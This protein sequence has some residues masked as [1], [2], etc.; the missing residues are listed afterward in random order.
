[1][2]DAWARGRPLRVE[3][4]VVAGADR[5]QPVLRL[6]PRDAERLAGF[7]H[8][9]LYEFA[10]QRL[11]AGRAG[12]L[13]VLQWLL[14]TGLAPLHVRRSWRL[15]AIA[16]TSEWNLALR[17]A[18]IAG[19]M[20]LFLLSLLLALAISLLQIPT[21]LPTLQ[22]VAAEVVASWSWLTGLGLAV[23]LIAA[24]LAVSMAWGLVADAVEEW[25]LRRAQL[26]QGWAGGYAGER[27]LWLQAALI[28]LALTSA[29]A[30]LAGFASR[31]AW[32]AVASALATLAANPSLLRATMALLA[33]GWSWRWLRSHLG[34]IALYVKGAA[35]SPF[36]RTRARLQAA[37]VAQ[38]RGLLLADAGYEVVVLVGHSLGSVL[39]LDALDI[40]AMEGATGGTSGSSPDL[41][42]L[43]GL[44]TFGS[45]LDKV[46]YLFRERIADDEA[47]RSQ[48]VAFWR[49]VRRRSE[50]R[51][52][53]PYAIEGGREGYPRL[54]WWHL[55]APLDPISDPL[56]LYR[57]DV[58]HTLHGVPWWA[59]H[60]HYW[61]DPRVFAL[62]RELLEGLAPSTTRHRG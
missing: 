21:L 6:H 34:D 22:R 61:R 59:A 7:V 12:P 58:R 14:Q 32:A 24:L 46:A 33:L 23:T 1:M 8:I 50:P 10:W 54:R 19:G 60:G 48:L 39:A 49:G 35:D 17:H 15:L 20:L 30:L 9:D 62:L 18:A 36:G 43:R 26:P 16:G 53:G 28:A 56:W 41:Q 11:V 13:G 25:A 2:T 4:L 5:P 27:R 31:D 57:V 44:F 52:A 38:L 51:D 55:H 42:R 47:V 40:L 29:L 37:L 45:P 3:P